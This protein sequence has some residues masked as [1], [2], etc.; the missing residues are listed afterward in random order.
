MKST[1]HKRPDTVGSHL[2]E[3]PGRGRLMEQKGEW[4][5]QALRRE[6]RWELVF[7]GDGVPVG[8]HGRVLETGGGVVTQQCECT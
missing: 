1:R 7:D 3:E 5:S 2:Y 6:E 8:D 4:W